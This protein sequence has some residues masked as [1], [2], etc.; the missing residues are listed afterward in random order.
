MR[1]AFIVLVMRRMLRA[2]IRRDTEGSWVLT[3]LLGPY[4]TPFGCP[5]IWWGTLRET[6]APEPSTSRPQQPR[7]LHLLEYPF[8]S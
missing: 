6:P 7:T 8:H 5:S 4:S 3:V 1:D 2:Y